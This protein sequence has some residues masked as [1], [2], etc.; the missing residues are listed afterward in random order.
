MNPNH[1]DLFGDD[2]LANAP[3]FHVLEPMVVGQP[4]LSAT[5]R[6]FKRLIESIEAYQKK[7]ADLENLVTTY[8][9]RF[10]ETLAPLITERALLRREMAFFMDAQLQRSAHASRWTG[11]QCETMEDV[12]MACCEELSGSDYAEGIDDIL[13]RHFGQ[14]DE[15]EDLA[16]A[17]AELKALFGIDLD[18]CDEH[19]APMS[20]DEILRKAAAHARALDDQAAAKEANRAEKRRARQ[21]PRQLQ[22]DQKAAEAAQSLKDIYRKLSSALHPDREPD[23]AERIRKSA[24]MAQVNKAYESGDLLKLL[25]LQYE[26][27]KVDARAA[28]QLADDKLAHMNRVLKAQEDELRT[29]ELMLI[30]QLCDQF[31][32]KRGAI[33]TEALD[34]SLADTVQTLKNENAVAQSDL[35]TVKQGDVIFKRWLKAQRKLYKASRNEADEMAQ[36]EQML[37]N[38]GTFAGVRPRSRR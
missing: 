1:P 23:D 33:T 19:G 28:M 35:A 11:P 15:D 25:Q 16:D 37:D 17:K 31:R 14:S 10:H 4:K 36:M 6:A 27:Q 9:P 29:R 21:S 18:E 34:L 2:P 12:L 13:E 24:L 30:R 7:V 3:V 26:T 20:P 38:L 32:L 5:Q 8:A 22:A